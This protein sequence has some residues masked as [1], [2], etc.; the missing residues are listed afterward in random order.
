[1]VA[2][3]LTG[4][5]SPIGALKPNRCT[6]MQYVQQVQRDK[7]TSYANEFANTCNV[8]TN[9]NTLDSVPSILL[10]RFL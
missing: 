4:A 10:L 7:N 8:S 9:K 1:M 2:L 5:L 3:R 6:D